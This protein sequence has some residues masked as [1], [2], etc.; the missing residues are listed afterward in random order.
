[1][2]R[3]E[4]SFARRLAIVV[5]AALAVRV[6][7]V[8]VIYPDLLARGLGG[9]D[10]SYYHGL[11]NLIA[12]GHGVIDPGVW[13][14]QHRSVPTADHAPL[15]PLLLS[16]LSAA[17][18]DGVLAHRLVG[19]VLGTLA[20]A[21][22]GLAGRRAGGE[23]VGLLAAAIAAGY[24]ILIA[25]DG[26][27][28]SE[29]LSAVLVLA[30]LLAAFRLRDCGRTRWAVA[31]G[32]AIG[33]AA[34]ARSETLLLVPLLAGPV[35]LAGSGPL[36]RRA[37]LLAL[38]CLA[39]LATIAPWTAR[40]LIT[41]DRP[42]LIASSDAS[43]VGGANCHPAYYG[44]STGGWR[45]DCLS[46]PPTGANNVEEAPRWRREGL[47]YASEHAGRVP[48]VMLRRV[49]L[50]WDLWL[51]RAQAMIATE[52]SLAV[53]EAGLVVFYCLLALAIV[54]ALVLRPW[55]AELW[56]LL[57]PP[58][59]VSVVSA[60]GY[61]TDRFRHPAEFTLAILAAVALERLWRRR[62]RLTP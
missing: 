38:V 62:R 36:R 37:G 9:G 53:Q 13:S 59:L 34:L 17:G 35:A 5:V 43:V 52:R 30:A 29:S 46:P 20:V 4:A 22:A 16:A 28:M 3:R 40:N 55:R 21:L 1:L 6:T 25:A 33:L 61:G 31:L 49:M 42:I 27:L 8:L 19:C 23:R 50:T 7:Y 14:A 32:G 2:T 18:A 24:P 45:P 58:V 57:V 44:R 60:I 51:P 48:V 47:T 39:T 11:A 56:I 26:S 12:A 15:W 10:W 54:G 41:F